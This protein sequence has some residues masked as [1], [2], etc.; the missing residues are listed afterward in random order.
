MIIFCISCLNYEIVPKPWTSEV[1]IV[2]LAVWHMYI[3]HAPFDQIVLW[4]PKYY[5]AS[6]FFLISELCKIKNQLSLLRQQAANFQLYIN[7]ANDFCWHIPNK[8][9]WSKNCIAR[10]YLHIFDKDIRT[11][12]NFRQEN[13][14]KITTFLQR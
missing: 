11:P 7:W 2:I 4:Y 5:L 6:P 10:Q 13:S 1:S 14:F 9:S 12:C 8:F 3:L